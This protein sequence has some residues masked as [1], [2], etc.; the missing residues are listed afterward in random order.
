ME[1]NPNKFSQSAVIALEDIHLQT[2]LDRASGNCTHTLLN[3]VK[4]H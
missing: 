1:L 4:L 3:Y 2:A